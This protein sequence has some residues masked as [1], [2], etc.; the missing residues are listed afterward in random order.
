[1]GSTLLATL[2]A[3]STLTMLFSENVE[4]FKEKIQITIFFGREISNLQRI[5]CF[6]EM[7]FFQNHLII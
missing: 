6:L 5:I 7:D 4:I 2:A 3:S 1:V